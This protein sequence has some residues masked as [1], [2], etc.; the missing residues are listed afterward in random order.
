MVSVQKGLLAV[1]QLLL[2][3]KADIHGRN[4]VLQSAEY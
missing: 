4:K 2:D 1:V 3:G